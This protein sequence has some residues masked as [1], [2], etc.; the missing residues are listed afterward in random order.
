LIVSP[1]R[2]FSFSIGIGKPKKHDAEFTVEKTC[3][4]KNCAV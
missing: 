2:L 4:G 3:I 1:G